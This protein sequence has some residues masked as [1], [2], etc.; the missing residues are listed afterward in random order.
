MSY[1]R[2]NYGYGGGY[3]S[4]GRYRSEAWHMDGGANDEGWH[5]RF[6]NYCGKETEHGR[7]SGCVPCGDRIA[8]ARARKRR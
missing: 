6:C 5:Y 2:K 4:T 8:A 7:G 1:W 3:D